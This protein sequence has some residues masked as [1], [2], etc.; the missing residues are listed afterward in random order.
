MKKQ[1]RFL[2]FLFSLCLLAFAGIQE[3]N[4]QMSGCFKTIA[5]GSQPDHTVG[6]QVNGTLWAWGY[7]AFGQ[8]GDGTIINK[9]TPTQIGTAA[10]WASV[11]VGASHTIA[12]KTDGTLWAWGNNGNGQLGDGTTAKKTIPTQIGTATNWASISAGG[13]Y[14]LALKTDGTLWAWGWNGSGQFGDG[15]ITDKNTPTQIGTDNNWASLSAGSQHSLAI[16]TNGTLWAWGNNGNGRLGD[17][18]TT[19]RNTPIQI[20]TATNWASIS[21]GQSHTLAIQ[22]DG[23]LWAWGSNAQGKLGNNGPLAGKTTP[24]QIGTSTN[25]SS[26]SAGSGHSFGIQTDGSLWAWGNNGNGRLGDG[27]TTIRT[28]PTKIGTTANWASIVSLASHSVAIQTDNSIWAWG[29]NG[30]GQL[31]DGT[32][33]EK[34]SPTQIS[35]CCTPSTSTTTISNCGSYVWNG[36][37]YSNS[38]IYTKTLVNAAG[39]DSTATLNLTLGSIKK[40]AYVANL[41]DN[42]VSV[43]D[44]S[45]NKVMSTFAVGTNPYSSCLSSDGNTL[46]VANPGSKDISVVNTATNRLIKT[47]AVSGA[48]RYVALNPQGTYLYAPIFGTNQM[49]IISTSSLEI[50]STVTVGNWPS[51]ICFSKDGNTAYIANYQDNTV[52]VFNTTTNSVTNTISTGANSTPEGIC[53]SPDGSKVYVATSS[54][55]SLPVIS[56]SSNSIVAT[57]TGLNGPLGLINSLDGSKL[58]VA[59][60][61]LGTVSVVNTSTNTVTK[62]I[63]V[64]NSPRGISISSDGTQLYVT[65]TGSNNLS[66]IDAST[67]QVINTI[68]TGTA[69]ISFGNFAGNV[70]IPCV[71]SISYASALVGKVGI[72]LASFNVTNSGGTAYYSISPSLPNG[73]SIDPNTGSISGTPTAI[74]AATDYTISASNVSGTTSTVLKITVNPACSPTTSSQTII[75][76]GSYTWNGTTYTSNGTYTKKLV[77]AEG[78]DSTATLVLTFKG[79]STF[80]NAL[81]F[82]ANN[83]NLVNAGTILPTSYTKEAWINLSATNYSNNIISGASDALHAFYVPNGVLTAGQSGNFAQVQDNV[84]LATNTWYHVA[85]SYDASTSTLKL[86]KNGVLLSTNTSVQPVSGSRVYLG[87]FNGDNGLQGALDEV[88]IWNKALTQTEIQTRMNDELSGTEPGLV[89][90]YN[91]N[92]GVAGGNN[93][94]I[95]TVTDKSSNANNGTLANF[96][97]NGSTSNFIAN[98]NQT[99]SS[100]VVSYQSNTTCGSYSWNGT[101]YTQSGNYAYKT[102]NAVGCD[103]TAF[104]NLTINQNKTTTL[105]VSATENYTWHGTTYTSSGSYTF[106]SL[107]AAGCDSLTMLNLTILPL[108]APGNFAYITPDTFKV[109]NSITPLSPSAVRAITKIGYPGLLGQNSVAVDAVGNVYLTINESTDKNTVKKIATDGVTVTSIGSDLGLNSVIAS[110]A[111]GNIY[112]ADNWNNSVKKIA[113]DGVTITTLGSGFNSPTAITVDA[114]GNVFVADN[115]GLIIKKIAPDGVTVTTHRSG[116]FG[117]NGLAVDASGSVYAAETFFNTLWKISP[118]GLTATTIGSGFSIIQSVTLDPAGNIY[119]ADAGNKA[120]K[121]IPYNGGSYGTPITINAGFKYPTGVAIDVAGNL[122]VSDMN[123]TAITKISTEGGPVSKYSISPALPNGLTIDTATGIISGTPTKASAAADYTV[124]ASNKGGGTT[125]LLNIS[126]VCTTTTSTQSVSACG[127]YTWHGTTYTA[128]GTYTYTTTNAIGCDSVV[129]LRLTIDSAPVISYNLTGVQT[130]N[131]NTAITPLMPTVSGGALATSNFITPSILPSDNSSMAIAVDS[132]GNVY[133]IGAITYNEFFIKKR[134]VFGNIALLYTTTQPAQFANS[135]GLDAKG[136][137]YFGWKDQNASGINKISKLSPDGKTT[138][139]TAAEGISAYCTIVV[140]KQGYIY[141]GDANNLYKIDPTGTSKTIIY[142]NIDVYGLAIDALDNIYVTS[143]KNTILKIAPNGT[144]SV[145]ATTDSGSMNFGL[146]VDAKGN[147]VVANYTEDGVSKLLKITPFGNTSILSLDDQYLVNQLSFDGESNLYSIGYPHV[148]LKTGYNPYFPAYSINKSLPTGLVFN[149][150]TGAISGT[151]TGLSNSTLYTITASSAKGCSSTTDVSIAV[152]NPCAP[153][154]SSATVSA[155]GSYT[156]NGTNYNT[157]GTYTFTT[158]NAAGCD[159]TATLVLT[160]NQPTTSSVTVNSPNSYTWNGTTYTTSGT[161]TYTTTNAAGCDSTATLELTIYQPVSGCFKTIAKGSTA[162]HTVGIQ[163]DGTLWAWGNNNNGQLG[164][165]TTTRKAT[166]TQIGT[167]TDWVSVAVGNT[168]TIAL[169]TDGTLWAWGANG[170]GQLGNGTTNGINTTTPTQIGTATNWASISAGLSHTLALKA[171][172]TLWAWGSNSN[173]Q[174]GNGTNTNNNNTPTQVGSNTNWASISAG[175]NYSMAIQTNGILWAWGSNSSGQ[176]GDGTTTESNTPVQIGTATNWA[177]VSAG[178]SHSL[179]IQ[180]DGT[181]WAWG[182]NS[183]GRLGDGSTTNRTAPTQIGTATNWS[184]VSAGGLHSLGVQTDGTLWAWGSNLS[185]RLGDG[186]TTNRSIPT[187][188]GTATNWVSIIGFNANSAAIQ[189]DKSIWAWGNNI[190]GQLGDGTT[191]NRT[192]PTQISTCSP[193][194]PTTSTTTISNCGSYVWNGTTYTTSGTYTKTLVNAAGCDSTAT[195]VLTITPCTNT[196]TGTVSNDWNN[197]ANWS[198]GVVPTVSTDA[199]IANTVRKPSISG[200][201]NVKNITISIGASLTNNGTLN[202]SGN[203]VN[204]GVPTLGGKGNIVLL[205]SSAAT[206]SGYTIFNNLEIAGN[207]SVGPLVADNILVDSIAVTGILKKTS[208]SLTTNGKVTLKSTSNQTALIQENGGTLTGNINMERYIG[209]ANGYHHISSPVTNNT[210]GNWGKYFSITGV[211]NIAASAAG[212]GKIATLQEY[213]E[214]A[215]KKS[216]LDSAFYHFTNPSAI[217]TS[218]KGLT[219][220]LSKVPTTLV[221]TGTPA[222]GTISVPVTFA[223]TNATTRGWNL[224]GNPYPSPISWS[225]LRSLNPGVWGDQACYIWKATKGVNGQWQTYNGTVGTNGVG[226]VIASTQAFFVLVNQSTNITYNNSIRTSDVNPT[227]FGSAQLQQLRLQIVNPANLAETDEVVAYTKVGI[228]QP[229]ASVKPPMPAEATNASL[230]FVHEG[231]QAA[232]EAL[233]DFKA[234]D[235]LALNISTPVAGVYLLKVGEY[236]NNL[237]AYLK[238]AKTGSYTELKA[239]TEIAIAT[240]ATTSNTRYSVVFGRPAAAVAAANNTYKVFAAKK[241][242][243]V[244]NSVAVN[245]AK[246]VVYNTL[247]QQIA[248]ATMNGTRLNIPVSASTN[249]TYVVKIAGE[250]VAKV[251]VP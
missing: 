235:E 138:T 23:T 58:Y 211:N 104:L 25:W 130:Y 85:L 179:A 131:T 92:Q 42:S 107:S 29:S 45:S 96:T 137:V 127:S 231:K 110:D 33:T 173:G 70:V 229:I 148:I 37:T 28:T 143:D 187:Q 19:Q 18:T 80:G 167:A 170:F 237:P 124:T 245:N 207:Y 203:W 190:F 197:A 182:N 139:L 27:T 174:L 249:A 210:V 79:H 243:Q 200:A 54:K 31:G 103:S 108:A 34:Y 111:V 183:A 71:P 11:A 147:V 168:Y 199:I 61:S 48:L 116:F 204:S 125:S 133:Y 244:T 44:I 93:T 36:T 72:N 246:V 129:T 95:T 82:N 160:I 98:T 115:N 216:I 53:I 91:F 250:I 122:Y 35:S 97:L 87:S 134:D 186:T 5:K 227:F 12:L 194:S 140:D 215:N 38:G 232:I 118:D 191:T 65:N 7:N 89:A 222:N 234:G 240:E 75:A 213:R 50:T 189:T 228:A 94:A 60:P 157:S 6:I 193:C 192:T 169:K 201:V 208:G 146:V 185:G 113:T 163:V 217:T 78:C 100:G 10:N 30:S 136:N 161:Y 239:G 238:D 230:S 175:G 241:A 152:V 47:I 196:W 128:S 59:N 90:Y 205:S 63:T 46:F 184:S 123:D 1:F 99:V 109:G 105:N 198:S 223:A 14:S 84:A 16:K 164:D 209:G 13:D 55:T 126:V 142:S 120:L 155:C 17:G 220:W 22:T 114:V 225:A 3:A 178:G 64:G 106:D 242:I 20:G 86:Y 145:F 24:T 132:F 102:T 212:V 68:S 69:P 166:P 66:V 83:N 247:G 206:L 76:C 165:G 236:N 41:S 156:W 56:T 32:T 218:G 153:T 180:T 221:S 188:I 224:I 149:D 2:S 177:S 51:A 88:R 21:A 176:L 195:L 40:M 151:P 154:T 52:S 26:V 159:S 248:T 135:F 150:T 49:S 74:N 162:N 121:K 9:S 8:I 117:V 119:V 57:I 181:L 141:V 43:I 226:N 73:L 171:D 219:A 67:D 15:T 233:A 172:G 101:T 251:I 214:S 158:T 4:A 81:N 77:N 202:I 62:S 112:V 39:C 144:S